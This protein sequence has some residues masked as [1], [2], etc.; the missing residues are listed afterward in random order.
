MDTTFVNKQTLTDAAWFQDVNDLTYRFGGSGSG[1][2]VRRAIVKL[3]ETVSVSDYVGADPTGVADSSLAFSHAIATG[4]RVYVGPG[5]WKCNIVVTTPLFLYADGPEVCSIS[6]F[7]TATAAITYAHKPFWNYDSLIAGIR[8]LGVG[9]VGVGVTMG[10]TNPADYVAG[11]E[12]CNNLQFSRCVFTGLDKGVQFPFGNIGTSFYSCAAIGNRYGYYLLNNKFGSVMHAGN[13]YWYDGA[14]LGNIV[15]IYIDN[16]ADGFGG[17]EATGTIFEENKINIYCN[18]N[19]ARQAPILRDCW[20]ES[21][22]A[23]LGG[24]S[25]IDS[26]AG[27]VVTPQV[28]VN[29]SFIFDGTTTSYYF[30]RGFLTDVYLKATAS[31]VLAHDVRVETQ[32]GFSGAPFT[33]DDAQSEIVLYNPETDGGILGAAR[34]FVE[35][36]AYLRRLD[37]SA[38]SVLS[39]WFLGRHRFNKVPSF[40]T[41]GTSQKCTTALSTT[42]LIVAGSLVSNGI[43]YPL[44]NQFSVPGGTLGSFATVPNTS[45]TPAAGSWV[46]VSFDVLWVSGVQPNFFYGDLNVNQLFNATTPPEVGVWYTVVGMG[47]A[48]NVAQ[49]LTFQG[50]TAASVFNLS[51]VQALNFATRHEMVA[52]FTSRAY[53]EGGLSGSAT[54][55]PPSL[56]DGVG[57]TTTVTVTGVA[58]A[59]FVTSVSFSLD[60]QGITLTAYI[61]GADTVS[62][63]FQNE[64]GGTLDLASGTLRVVVAKA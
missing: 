3:Q 53:N 32:G 54:Y 4:K 6:P 1:P 47:P 46:F 57:T 33:V 37:N 40:G 30:D 26:W 10:K 27:T 50:N 14:I 5:T 36:E 51:A 28:V 41:P 48:S 60:L 24:S 35:G 23:L 22:G 59:D 44:C 45:T 62:V 64:S 39:R 55:N 58:L 19:N 31:R 12:L 61:S 18:T 38:T 9:M 21:S 16:T 56:A 15:G 43:L 29:R 8:F 13:K 52:Y 34:V 20:N 11:D 49:R 42:D 17:V 7:S 25:T 63:R 2:A